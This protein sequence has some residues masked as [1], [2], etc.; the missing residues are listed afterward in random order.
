MG[1]DTGFLQWIRE[2][3]PRRPIDE[4]LA[5]FKG[6]VEPLSPEQLHQ[7][8]GRCMDCGVPFC[9]QGC[10][11]GNAIPD[12]NDRVHNG[13]FK[14]AWRTLNATNNFPEFTG[15]L[16]PAPCEAACT[17]NINDDPVTIEQ[18]EKEIVERAFREG[19]IVPRPPLQR[20]G[21]TVAVVGSGPAGLAAAAQ[22]NQAGHSVTVYE[23]ADRIGG[24]LRYG[25]PDFK[26]EKWVID[27]RL[28]LMRA[29][30]VRFETSVDVGVDPTWTALRD[31]HDAV[32]IC[33]GA[34]RPR[35]LNVPGAELSGVH[36]ALRYLRQQNR[37]VAGEAVPNGIS[38]AGKHVLILGGGDTGSD[39]L[40]TALR[41]G[42]ASVRQ[43]ELMPAPPEARDANNPWPKW[44]LMFR[45]SSSQAEGGAR[46]FALMT[47]SLSGADGQLSHL[48]AREVTLVDGRPVPT[49]DATTLQVDLLFLAMGFLGPDLGDLA[50]NLGVTLTARG[51]IATDPRSFATNVPGVFAA[52]DAVKGASLIVWAISQGREAAHGVDTWLR[53]TPSALPTRGADQSFG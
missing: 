43:I 25:I 41:Q 4:R 2:P 24:L 37:R 48:H 22:L 44:P 14:S 46:Q 19:L 15:R 51:T 27:R 40:G 16:C 50:E 26:L 53:G 32:V 45:T 23:R 11:L 12:W 8:A 3:A 33:I 34:G 13:A 49:G 30:G 52:G 5:H 20:T 42:A 29:E 31:T 1:K 21:K 47:Q 7:Q 10:P 9:H 39:C 28:A 6:F 38:A 36:F 17:L 35:G 18:I